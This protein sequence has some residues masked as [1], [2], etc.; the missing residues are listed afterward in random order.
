[1]VGLSDESNSLTASFLVRFCEFVNV[2][3]SGFEEGEGHCG[4][5]FFPS[6][7]VGREFE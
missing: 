1:M 5:V 6:R 3:G 7:K 2:C 4:E